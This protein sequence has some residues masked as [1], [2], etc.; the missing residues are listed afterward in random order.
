[1]WCGS[2]KEVWNWKN[3][4]VESERVERVKY[5][6]CGGKDAV[7]RREV[8]RNEKREVFCPPCKTGKKTLWWNWGRKLERTV[9]KAQRRR[10]R[11]TDLRKVT[12]TIN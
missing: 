7:I 4:E 10:V 11:I 2:C 1:M 9:P 3:R 6:T 5:S 12:G 8:E